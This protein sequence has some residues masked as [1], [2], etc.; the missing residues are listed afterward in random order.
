MR[1]VWDSAKAR[2]NLRKHGVDFA[3]AAVAVEDENA[4]TIEDRDHTEQR[5]KT[6]CLDPETRVLLVVHA[7]E[8]SAGIRIISARKATKAEQRQY[9]QGLNHE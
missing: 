8:G 9:W 6:L 5:F 7:H 1:V 2:E 4:L 3:D